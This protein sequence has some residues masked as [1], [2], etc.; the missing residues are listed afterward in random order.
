VNIPVELF[1]A[2][3]ETMNATGKNLTEITNLALEELTLRLGTAPS[4]VTMIPG[5]I[6]DPHQVPSMPTVSLAPKDDSPVTTKVPVS[7]AAKYVQE[8]PPEDYGSVRKDI[9]DGLLGYP[10]RDE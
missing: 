6:A 10:K 2:I 8:N 4:Y 1:L 3:Q 5:K 7:D 9:L